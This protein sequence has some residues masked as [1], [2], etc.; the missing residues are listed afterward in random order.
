MANNM[1]LIGV[2]M[3]NHKKGKHIIV[4]KL[5]HPS[6][7]A[8]CDYLESL[9]FEISYVNNDEELVALLR[10]L[11]KI[12]FN[13]NDNIYKKYN[14]TLDFVD[15]STIY[16]DSLVKK[17]SDVIE[18]HMK[19]QK[20]LKDSHDVYGEHIIDLFKRKQSEKMYNKK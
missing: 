3:H 17:V 15:K 5:E 2:A 18:E 4:S 10:R 14:S 19:I 1:A 16:F 9:G 7:Y 12:D 11:E 8:I 6:I 13:L 20:E